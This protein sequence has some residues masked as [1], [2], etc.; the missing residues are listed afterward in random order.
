MI[1]SGISEMGVTS[2]KFSKHHREFFNSFL[3]TP[4][5]SISLCTHRVFLWN[6]LV[7][8]FVRQGQLRHISWPQ[9]GKFSHPGPPVDITE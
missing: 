5:K 7:T 2:I 8:K 3:S 1:R 6:V 4:P 9:L